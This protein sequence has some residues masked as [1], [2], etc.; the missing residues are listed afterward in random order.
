MRFNRT[1]PQPIGLDVGHDSVK[2]LQVQTAGEST[3][4]AVAAA[5][6]YFPADVRSQPAVRVAA[7][8]EPIR[9]LLRDGGFV[10]RRVVAALP[11]EIVHVK[12]FRLPAMP[13]PEMDAAVRYEAPNLFGFDAAEG[14]VQWV[15]A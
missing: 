1:H 5:R 12:N 10:G 14:R 13:E 3:I 6:H 4:R 2:L 7:A 9:K 8:V 11:R 15:Q